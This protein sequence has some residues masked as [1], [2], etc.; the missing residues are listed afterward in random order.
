MTPRAERIRTALLAASDPRLVRALGVLVA[1][2]LYKLWAQAM[3]GAQW[4][5]YSFLANAAA[6]AGKGYGFTEPAR[7]PLISVVAAPLL[8]FGFM[9]PFAIQLVD[10][11]FGMFC[12]AGV[13]LLVRRRMGVLPAAGAALA[14]LMAPPVWEW[15]AVGYTDLGAVALCIWALLA[16]TKATEEDPRYYAAAF[17]LLVCAALMRTTSLLFVLP[18]GV[19]M[20][21]RSQPFRHIRYL[22]L[23][24]AAALAVYVPFGLYYSSAV[25]SPFYPFVT[26]LRIKE[27]ASGSATVTHDVGSYLSGLPVLAAPEP[28]AALTLFILFVAVIGIAAGVLRSLKERHV[29][30]R[31]LVAAFVVIGCAAFIVTRTGL[32]AS[33]AVIAIAVYLTW[34]LLAADEYSVEGGEARI[35]PASLA[36]DAS[37]VAWLLSYYAFHEAWAQRVTRYYITMAPQVAYLVALAW[38]QLFKS[39]PETDN[40]YVPRF[41]FASAIRD[42]LPSIRRWFALPLIV[43]IVGA[44]AFDV[45]RT[46]TTPDPAIVDSKSTAQYLATQPGVEDSTVYS[47]M[48]PVTAWYL[49]H[50]VEAMPMFDSRDAVDHELDKGDAEY[51]V[52]K[53]G[54]SAQTPPPGF[55]LAYAAPIQRVF[56]RVTPPPARPTVLYFGAGWENYLENL[57]GFQ[58]YLQHSEGDYDLE[59]SRFYDA[60]TLDELKRYPVVVGFGGMWHNRAV[61]ERLLMDYVEQGGTLIFDASGNLAEPYRLDGSVLFDTVIQREPVA[62]DGSVRLDPAFASRHALVGPVAPS[63]WLSESGEPWYGAGYRELPGSPRLKVLATVSGKPLVAE[64]SWGKGR[65][66]WIAYNLPWHAKLSES[67]AEAKLVSAIISEA[68]SQTTRQAALPPA[69]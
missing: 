67:T 26:S 47:D 37:V 39:L 33:Q 14:V 36:L 65:V 38:W 17:P 24:A 4:D 22:L 69:R 2:A 29:S 48:W 28:M 52:S 43:L 1:M 51:F 66:I 53:G 68:T 15:L 49:R 63:A 27:A 9:S 59:G 46:S 41:T 57:N 20:L 19:W 62:R 10:F 13:F 18:F 16:A 25:G 34:R 50:P 23:G 44:F 3:A 64:R 61:A 32:M 56:K 5:T 40:A 60:F 30:A 58:T 55:R 54:P 21:L 8:R 12:L 6:L 7:P 11:G 31:R 42:P 35:V 45:A